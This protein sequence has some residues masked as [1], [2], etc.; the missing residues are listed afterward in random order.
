MCDGIEVREKY[1]GS[2]DDE[3]DEYE[4]YPSD[5][6]DIPGLFLIVVDFCWVEVLYFS[7]ESSQIDA[8]LLEPVEDGQTGV[9]KGPIYD[10]FELVEERNGCVNHNCEI[11]HFSSTGH[12]GIKVFY[13]F[14]AVF[15][16]ESW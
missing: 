1:H 14:V 8:E 3:N 5:N 2:K 4:P 15:Y 9:G 16:L 12:E 7:F 6:F 10:D 13:L 11:V